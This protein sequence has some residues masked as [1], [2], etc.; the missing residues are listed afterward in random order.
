MMTTMSSARPTIMND[1]RFLG[2]RPA[3]L[4]V[5]SL[6]ICSIAHLRSCSVALTIERQPLLANHQ[7]A[8]VNDLGNHVD[9]AFQVEI[10]EARLF[11]LNLVKGWFFFRS[12][13]DVSEPVIV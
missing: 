6:I 2:A 7:I 1:C 5:L 4:A 12:R 11:V 8:V 3:G 13:L 10:D 9:A